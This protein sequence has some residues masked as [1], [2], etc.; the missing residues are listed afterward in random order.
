MC[1]GSPVAQA[2]L[3]G[4]LFLGLGPMLLSLPLHVS[5]QALGYGHALT[6]EKKK[7]MKSLQLFCLLVVISKETAS[8]SQF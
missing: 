5:S 4:L 3:H 2:F 1:W 6:F 8:L 7:K